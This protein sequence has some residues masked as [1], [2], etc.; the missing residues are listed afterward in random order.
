MDLNFGVWDTVHIVCCPEIEDLRVD[1][2]CLWKNAAA[3]AVLG[4]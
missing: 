3:V 1:L 2:A 4:N